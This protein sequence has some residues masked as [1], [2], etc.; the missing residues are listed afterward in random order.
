MEKDPKTPS[1]SHRVMEVTGLFL[2]LGFTAFGGPAAHIAI[3]HDQVV[4]RRK[5]LDDQHFLDLLGATRPDCRRRLLYPPC[6]TDSHR[7][8]MGLCPLRHTAAGRRHP[9]R[10]QTRHHRYYPAGPVESW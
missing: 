5:W 3:M 2:K 8:I 9:L 6:D 1:L 7:V 10:H 4:K